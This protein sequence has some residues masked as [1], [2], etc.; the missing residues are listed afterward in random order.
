[1]ESKVPAVTHD[2]L[3]EG[4]VDDS[5]DMGEIVEVPKVN[6][7]QGP[8]GED[9]QVQ[10]KTTDDDQTE[11]DEE[12][13]ETPEPPSLIIVGG[14]WQA[15]ELARLNPGS[16]IIERE[17]S[18]V[19]R[20]GRDLP[21]CHILEGDG[22]DREVLEAAGALSALWLVLLTG[23]DEEN[24]KVARTAREAFPELQILSG[25][26]T[27]E[28]GEALRELGVQPIP[29]GTATLPSVLNELIHP[30]Q[31]SLARVFLVAGH[32]WVDQRLARIE[33]PGANQVMAVR[34]GDE[35]L[36][37]NPEIL[38]AENDTLLLQCTDIPGSLVGQALSS[39]ETVRPFHRFLVTMTEGGALVGRF[40]EAL[41]LA[42]T[43][44]AKLM[45]AGPSEMKSLMDEATTEAE[46]V[47]VEVEQ[48]QWTAGGVR[49]LLRTGGEDEIGVAGKQP[50]QADCVILAPPERQ[51]IV[52][53]FLGRAPMINTMLERGHPPILVARTFGPYRCVLFVIDGRK[54]S[55]RVTS[56]ALRMARLFDARLHV[57]VYRGYD[58][59]KVESQRRT[60]QQAIQAY[61]LELTETI[62]ESHRG[63]EFIQHLRSGE[64][65]LAV[66]SARSR[67]LR[68]DLL[69]TT[70]LRASCSLLVIP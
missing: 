33:V 14:S 22:R 69:V 6:G 34:R 23:S 26:D 43:S 11:G 66:T 25:L 51:G 55:Q 64:V 47:K 37:P 46:A 28:G 7:A 3:I 13:S 59:D 62:I 17:A 30:P 9:E 57:L 2:D 10:P 20:L 67:T 41:V 19:K 15:M 45:L 44:G 27:K 42:Q 4:E 32:P 65:D 5:P 53:W 58:H 56:Y 63:L 8:G 18:W 31:Q 50:Q 61:R 48:L 40:R 16:L 36:A 60:L 39:P 29:C 68:R 1:M 24:L 38:L 21:E 54:L 70:L 52:D 12:A 49:E 35:L